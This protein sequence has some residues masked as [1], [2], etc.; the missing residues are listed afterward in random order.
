MESFAAPLAVAAP[1][2][3]PARIFPANL[4]YLISLVLSLAIGVTIE[5]WRM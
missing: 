2:A 3:T 5:R 4:L 1:P